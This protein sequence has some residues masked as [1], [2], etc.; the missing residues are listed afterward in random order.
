MAVYTNEEP[1]PWHVNGW[2]TG[3]GYLGL[4]DW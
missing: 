2:Q 1:D 4:L 3:G